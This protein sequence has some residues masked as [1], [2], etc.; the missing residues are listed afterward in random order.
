MFKEDLENSRKNF[1]HLPKNL[2][3]YCMVGETSQN[4]IDFFSAVSQG[5]IKNIKR[6]FDLELPEIW[7]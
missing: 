3:S 7:K 6:D 2:K 1:K 5:A 4:H